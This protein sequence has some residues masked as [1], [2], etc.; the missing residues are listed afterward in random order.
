MPLPQ[1]EDWVNNQLGLGEL[2]LELVYKLYNLFGLA[3]MQQ[4][5]YPDR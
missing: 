3:A 4:N 1:L 2:F 5:L